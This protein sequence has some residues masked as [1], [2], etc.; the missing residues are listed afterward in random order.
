[1]EDAVRGFPPRDYSKATHRQRQAY[2]TTEKLLE[3]AAD[4]PIIPVY[5]PDEID[6]PKVPKQWLVNIFSAVLGDSFREW[7]TMQV[8]ERNNIMNTKKEVMIAMDPQMAAKFEASTHVSRKCY[9][10]SLL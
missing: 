6:L 4:K 8:E 1:M 2:L 5:L 3:F 7:V 10:S 9:L